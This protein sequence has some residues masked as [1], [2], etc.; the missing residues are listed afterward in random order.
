MGSFGSVMSTVMN[1]PASQALTRVRFFN[2]SDK[3]SAREVQRV[4]AAVPTAVL[5]C[6]LLFFDAIGT[7]PARREVFSKAVF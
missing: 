7:Q 6:Q 1:S 3:V 4:D 5:G 2:K